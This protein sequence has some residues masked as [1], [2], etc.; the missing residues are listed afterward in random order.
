MHTHD[1]VRTLNSLIETC[2]NADLT[3]SRAAEHARTS[4]LRAFLAGR[5]QECRQCREELRKEVIDLGGT[6]GKNGAASGTR[7]RSWAVLLSMVSSDS[8]RT[9]L[10]ACELGNNFAMEDYRE[11]LSQPLPDDIRQ[12]LECQFEG[13]KHTHRMI[14]GLRAE[15]RELHC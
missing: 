15:A 8:D 7:K 13:V 3:F 4:D 12:L 9:M 10:E 6:P 11:A 2:D 14:R 5:A 1:P